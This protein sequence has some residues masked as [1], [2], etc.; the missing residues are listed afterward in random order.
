MTEAKA[1]YK[2]L[3]SFE[4]KLVYNYGFVATASSH[5]SKVKSVK[6]RL[7][8]AATD[9]KKFNSAKQ[10]FDKLQAVQKGLIVGSYVEALGNLELD[11]SPLADLDDNLSSFLEID[12]LAEFK[13]TEFEALQKELNSLSSKELKS[14]KDYSKYQALVKD[15]KAVDSFK[16]KMLK[17]G[18]NPTYSNKESIYKSY[19]KLTRNQQQL[20]KS[21]KNPNE[22]PNEDSEDGTLFELLDSWNKEAASKAESLNK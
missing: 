2:D 6:T 1:M 22:D 15:L 18:N 19:L 7:L 10:A 9:E 14:L 12:D 5:L 8:A 16:A 17:L 11:D 21:Y 20:F 13:K 3:N 4:K